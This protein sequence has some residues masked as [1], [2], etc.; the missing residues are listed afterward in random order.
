MTTRVRKRRADIVGNDVTAAEILDEATHR[1]E[2][3]RPLVTARVGD[4]HRFAA[5]IG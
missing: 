5:K 2:Q 3:R 4:D 1:V